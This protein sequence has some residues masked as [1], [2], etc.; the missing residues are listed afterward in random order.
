[1]IDEA[2]GHAAEA[3]ILVV[4]AETAGRAPGPSSAIWGQPRAR[5]Q[6]SGR[7]SRGPVGARPRRQYLSIPLQIERLRLIG[8]LSQADAC[9][10]LHHPSLP[11]EISVAER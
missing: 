5:S 7:A 9:D 4:P 11:S 3:S 8:G 6:S 10:R 1:G 2:G